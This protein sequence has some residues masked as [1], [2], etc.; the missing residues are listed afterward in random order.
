MQKPFYFASF[1]IIAL[2]VAVSSLLVLV[3]W[4]FDQDL[5][6]PNA[7]ID[8]YA[9]RNESFMTSFIKPLVVETYVT[10]IN[11]IKPLL[12]IIA[13]SYYSPFVRG[14]IDI[15]FLYFLIISFYN[16]ILSKFGT[17]IYTQ[18]IL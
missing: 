3:R 11:L 17:F 16:R 8:L 15:T 12:V 18:I 4:F 2:L 9:S 7:T 14:S 6:V 5:T 10:F 1:I 13:F